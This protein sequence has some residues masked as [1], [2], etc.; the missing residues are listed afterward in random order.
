MPWTEFPPECVTDSTEETESLARK[1]ALL[2]ETAGRPR[3]VALFGDLGVGKTAFVRGFVSHFAPQARVKSPTFS[4][5]N[6]YRNR[7]T[8][9]RILHFDLYRIEN[10]DDLYSIGYYDEIEGSSLCLC[11]WCEKIPSALPEEYLEV[12][13][14]KISPDLPDKRRLSF[15]M[16][17]GK[18]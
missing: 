3:F 16:V 7:K 9:I 10:D 5:V 6:E 18:A 12:K 4:L 17:K 11:E 13:I 1:A 14:E 2:L 15:R 8:G